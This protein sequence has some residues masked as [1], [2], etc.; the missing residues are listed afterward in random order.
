MP[1][2]GR[3]D[4]RIKIQKRDEIGD[5]SDDFAIDTVTYTLILE[6]WAEALYNGGAKKY[7]NRAVGKSTGDTGFI[8]RN[9]DFEIEKDHY[10]DA[11]GYRY[12]VVGTRPMDDRF[13]FLYLDCIMTN[14]IGSDG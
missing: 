3:L 9:V 7:G 11:R 5:F 8:I 6:T 4:T 2:I 13:R 14:K 12:Q 1:N 10:V